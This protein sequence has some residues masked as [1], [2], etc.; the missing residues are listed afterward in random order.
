MFVRSF[1]VLA[2]LVASAVVLIFATACG[3]DDNSQTTPTLSEN[4]TDISGS[5]LSS[6]SNTTSDPAIGSLAPVVTGTDL[7]TG[8]AVS[9]A[10]S[11]AAGKPVM[12]GFYA[13]WCPHCQSEIPAVATGLEA[14]PLPDEIDFVAMSTFVDAT[15]GNHPPK[16][17]FKREKWSLPVVPDTRGSTVAETFGVKS[18]PFLVLVDA[19][20]NIA[21]R[22]PGSLGADTLHILASQLI[23]GV[24]IDGASVTTG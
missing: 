15:R 24:T 21:A 13:H 1:A 8:V 18:V 7:L 10:D 19:A 23:D 3:S 16:A 17:W 2:A 12:I 5:A 4:P 20:G 22:V 6:Y 14:N 11:T 9:T